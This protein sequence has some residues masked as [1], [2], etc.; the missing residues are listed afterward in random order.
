[1]LIDSL[2]KLEMVSKLVEMLRADMKEV[3]LLPHRMQA[4]YLPGGKKKKKK[5]V[6]LT[7]T[8]ER[9]AALEQLKI[10]GRNPQNADPLFTPEVS[11]LV[12]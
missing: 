1:M 2:G 3:N 9:N 7:S 10:F 5:N 6:I 8:I 11:V 4:I 12:V